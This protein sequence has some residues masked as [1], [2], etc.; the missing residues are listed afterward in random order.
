[1]CTL[2]AAVASL[3]H[4]GGIDALLV[5]NYAER[6]KHATHSA[7]HSTLLIVVKNSNACKHLTKQR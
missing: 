1:M 6:L 2:P 4:T 7:M 3:L 5:Q